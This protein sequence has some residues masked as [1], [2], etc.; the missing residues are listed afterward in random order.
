VDTEEQNDP[1][2]SPERSITHSEETSDASARTSS[3]RVEDELKTLSAIESYEGK[4]F[5]R[6]YVRVPVK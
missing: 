6:R 3:E 2:E 5:Q 4:A 1:N